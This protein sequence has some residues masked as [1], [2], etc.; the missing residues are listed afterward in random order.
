MSDT[1]KDFSDALAQ[2]HADI[3]RRLEDLLASARS[4]DR[5]AL[6]EAFAQAEDGLLAHMNAEELYVLPAFVVVDAKEAEALRAEHARMREELGKLGIAVQLHVIRKEQVDAL[7]AT[8]R[9]HASREGKLM[10]RWIDTSLPPENLR[11]LVA[12]IR[13]SWKARGFVA[14][15][16]TA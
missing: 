10:Y 1:P 12:R 9:E 15:T 16:R 7:V 3:A 2:D 8:V 13:A 4:D 11:A 6:A 5:E 14:A